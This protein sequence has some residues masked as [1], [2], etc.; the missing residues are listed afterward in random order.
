VIALTVDH[1]LRQEAA[2]EAAQVGLWLKARGIDHAVLV[3]TREKPATGLQA[4]ARAARYR[5]L[6]DYCRDQGILHLALAHH[7]EDQAETVLLRF[8]KGSGIDG[9]AGMAAIREVGGVRLLRPLLGMPRER[10]T[11]TLTAYGQPWIEDPS[12]RSTAFARVRLRNAAGILA[13]EGL[14]PDR[15]ADM[16]RRAGRARS[17][18]AQATAELLARAAELWPEGCVLLDSGL[19]E[20]ASDEL[21][22]RALA[23]CLM[24]VGGG[25][26]PPR[27][28]GLE[29]LRS[30]LP[31]RAHTL[32]GCR[33]LPWRDRTL[34][35]R[36]ARAADERLNLSAGG[37][38]RWDGRFLV[39]RSASAESDNLKLSS[40]T[41]ARLGDGGWAA[42]CRDRPL[43]KNS[44]PARLPDV[45]RA[46]L[47]A[48]WRDGRPVGLP[49]PG[50]SD[51]GERSETEFGVSVVFAP[52]APLCGPSFSVV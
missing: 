16:A 14:T 26:H 47:P 46:A 30:A 32:A 33:I 6:I 12:N 10:L 27:L 9:L 35:A 19:L 42:L 3:W 20:K 13:A 31:G 39:R 1:G 43:W 49:Q 2:D 28:D 21:A 40:V 4:A 24:V 45:V 50:F 29:R 17:A 41:V 8:A 7:R 22:L 34:I 48:L 18:L 23:R 51:A 36:E 5:L 37:A 25:M 52:A 38:V 15:L 11:A 44:A